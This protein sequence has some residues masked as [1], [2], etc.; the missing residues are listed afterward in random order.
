M[1]WRF[2]LV[3]FAAVLIGMAL[4]Q[5]IWAA[6]EV[7]LGGMHAQDGAA[8]EADALR[9]GGSGLVLLGLIGLASTAPVRSLGRTI[10]ELT[11]RLW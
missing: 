10:W 8:N 3:M 4:F 1:R 2:L 11:Y 9:T 7:G 5:F 6:H